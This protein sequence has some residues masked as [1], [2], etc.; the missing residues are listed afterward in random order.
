MTHKVV[1]YSENQRK[2]GPFSPTSLSH[3]L[4]DFSG[5]LKSKQEGSK[6]LEF[7]VNSITALSWFCTCC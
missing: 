1:I 7:K 4:D 2:I 3:F 6:A 5:N